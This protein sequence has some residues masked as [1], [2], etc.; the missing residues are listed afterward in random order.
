MFKKDLERFNS[1]QNK[2]INSIKGIF[3][4]PGLRAI[5]VYR[6]GQYSLTLN[7]LFVRL[8][9]RLIYSVLQKF[10]E[11]TSMIQIP[12][13]A[14]IGEGMYIGHFGY[15]VINSRTKIGNNVTL[16][17]GVVIGNDGKDIKAVP[18]I[19]N[20]VFIGTGAK[21]IG[22]VTIGDAVVIAPNSVVTKDIPSHCTVGGIPAKVISDNDSSSLILLGYS[23]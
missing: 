21:I 4:D 20:N 16:A 5:F 15:I 13:G 9:L 18:V 3:F 22:G 6:L 8:T 23:L 11:S 12:I 2:S 7:N 19:G 17:P 1:I 14:D 10:V